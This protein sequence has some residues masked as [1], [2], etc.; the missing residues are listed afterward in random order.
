MLGLAAWRATGGGVN[1]SGSTGP[2]AATSGKGTVADAL[3][4]GS[5][6]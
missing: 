4:M 5:Q 6:A 2:H 1:R 3:T